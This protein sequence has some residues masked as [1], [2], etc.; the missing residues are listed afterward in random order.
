MYSSDN[1]NT[2]ANADGDHVFELHVN[3]PVYAD[4]SVIFRLPIRILIAILQNI[5]TN[6]YM[7]EFT[8][9]IHKF[10]SRADK[11]DESGT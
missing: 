11:V 10:W 6:L 7:F 9:E 4:M 2:F 1:V 5:F 3:D 8:T